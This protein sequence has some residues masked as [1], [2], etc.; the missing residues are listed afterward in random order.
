MDATLVNAKG[1]PFS[2]S[3]SFNPFKRDLFQETRIACDGADKSLVTVDNYSVQ[4]FIFGRR[5]STTKRATSRKFEGTIDT[6]RGR[7]PSRASA[8]GDGAR[9]RCY[10]TDL[11]QYRLITRCITGI[12]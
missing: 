8:S 2:G 4:L 9:R 3:V 7:I 5:R 11:S 1:R 12:A 10:Q 6:R